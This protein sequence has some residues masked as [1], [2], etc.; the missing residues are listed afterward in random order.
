MV[1][2]ALA[3]DA[4]TVDGGRTT[5]DGR[6]MTAMVSIAPCLLCYLGFL[7]FFRCVDWGRDCARGTPSGAGG[8]RRGTQSVARDGWFAR[9]A[10]R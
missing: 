10:V 9:R 6:W 8:F 7:G 4:G 1:H 3:E 2:M 5:D